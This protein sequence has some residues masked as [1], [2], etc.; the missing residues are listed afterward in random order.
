M[1]FAYILKN[2]KNEKLY[3][4]FKLID[5]CN[6]KLTCIYSFSTYNTN[7]ASNFQHFLFLQ[8][9]IGNCNV[10][11]KRKAKG[12]KIGMHTWIAVKINVTH[13]QLY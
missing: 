2:Y 4:F 9:Y 5:R 8:T 3:I 6:C 11:K 12:K 7:Y 13:D 1:H 10:R